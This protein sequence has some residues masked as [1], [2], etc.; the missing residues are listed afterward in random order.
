M[1]KRVGTGVGPQ[2]SVIV[3]RAETPIESAND[4]GVAA[5]NEHPRNSGARLLRIIVA[6]CAV[7]AALPGCGP[8]YRGLRHMGQSAVLRGDFGPARHFFL[9]AE[10]KRP[11][12]VENLHD[13]GVC[14]AVLAR[15]K[16]EQMN[17]AAAFR[18]VDDAIDYYRRSIDVHPGHQASLEGL[19][20]ALELKGQFDEALEQAHWA[21]EFVGPSARQQI[22]L[23]RELEQRGDV[24]GARLRYRQGVAMEPRNPEAYVAMAWFCLRHGNESAAVFHFQEAYR[25][26]PGDADVLEQL[27]IRSAVPQIEST[28]HRKP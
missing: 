12:R 28:R 14:S 22:F 17:H 10:E 21:A 18:E 9:Q 8:T 11:R 1:T 3:G 27:A 26:D 13:L 15:Q 5:M 7:A 20:V 23:A 4:C 6:C 16:F 25:L 19:N 24:D 2:R